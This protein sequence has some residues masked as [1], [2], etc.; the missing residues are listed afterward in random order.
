MEGLPIDC[1]SSVPMQ[2]ANDVQDSS[3]EAVGEDGASADA[4][5]AAT[6]TSTTGAHGAAELSAAAG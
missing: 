2:W 5:A 6:P 4:A 3:K 1:M